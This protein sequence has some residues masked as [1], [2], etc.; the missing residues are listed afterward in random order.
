[1]SVATQARMLFGKSERDR[2]VGRLTTHLTTFVVVNTLH[3]RAE[4]AIDR[5]EIRF[6]PQRATLQPKPSLVFTDSTN[7]LSLFA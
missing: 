1:M 6:A 7:P 2:C 5:F 4:S 3:L